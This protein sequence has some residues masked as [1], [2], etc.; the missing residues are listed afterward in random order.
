[1]FFTKLTSWDHWNQFLVSLSIFAFLPLQFPQILRNADV[2][3]TQNPEAIATLTVLPIGGY[4]SAM[5]G[6]LLLMNFLAGQ[7]EFWG[8]A[9]QMVGIVTTAI[10]LAQLF[11]VGFIPILLF[12]PFIVFL[13]IGVVINYLNF[14]Y[15][16]NPF[17]SEKIWPKWRSILQLVGIALLPAFAVLQL[18][19]A[20][21]PQLPQ[22]PGGLG[23]A[24]LMSV[25]VVNLVR[26]QADTF[27]AFF[28]SQ[29]RWRKKVMQSGDW[30]DSWLRRGWSGL[31]GW[32]A[33]LL[34]MFNP[35]SQLINSLIHADSLAALSIS[36]QVFCVVG[37]L[38]MLSRS[39]TLLIE[40]KDRIWCFSSLWDTAMRV[41]IFGCLLA[42]GL[43]SPMMFSLYVT[44]IFLYLIFIYFMTKRSSPDVS[45]GK[46]LGFLFLG[47]SE[48][49][50]KS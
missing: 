11:Q 48:V 46:T 33:N 7:R 49:L 10:L 15:S 27:P 42:A 44:G 5:L 21:F 38:L 34:F 26:Q 13:G 23:V 8:T 4:A 12:I 36:T 22:W 47:Q 1:M 37:N 41:G 6:N 39:G 43:V 50:A 30:I 29:N 2:I 20:L 18:H 31:A 35:L 19:D 3:A 24:I 32:T 45:L 28:R 40:G 16:E 17:W 14:L 25:F 9:V